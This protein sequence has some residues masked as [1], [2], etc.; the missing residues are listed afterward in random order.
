MT[1][2]QSKGG[3]A[4]VLV[5]VQKAFLEWE[6]AG[7]RRNNPQAV[8]NIARLLAA[9]RRAGLPVFHIRLAFGMRSA[10]RCLV[11]KRHETIGRHI[12]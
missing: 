9:F 8:D 6:A 12:H 3:T 2:L 10:F 7:M 4:L 1:G 11:E 5:D